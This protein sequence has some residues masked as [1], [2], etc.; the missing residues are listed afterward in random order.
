[1]QDEDNQP[2]GS[3]PVITEI[4]ICLWVLAF[5]AVGALIGAALTVAIRG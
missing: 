4:E 2:L 1:M 5:M 3:P